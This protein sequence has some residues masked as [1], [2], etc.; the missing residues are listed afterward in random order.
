MKSVVGEFLWAS[1]AGTFPRRRGS[2]LSQ[3]DVAFTWH[4]LVFFAWRVPTVLC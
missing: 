2:T 1:I 4:N 3:L